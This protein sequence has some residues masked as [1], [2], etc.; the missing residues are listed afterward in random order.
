[1]KARL[2]AF[3]VHLSA[4]VI[5]ALFTVA[6][7]FFLWYPAPLQKAIGVTHI[8]LLILAID[9]ILGPLMTLVIYKTDKRKMAFDLTVIILLQLGAYFYG[10]HTV[11]AGRPAWLVFEVDRFTVVRPVDVQTIPRDTPERYRAF[12]LTGPEWVAGRVPTDPQ[13]RADL[14]FSAL[15]DGIDLAQRPDLYVP[16]VEENENLRANAQPLE[17]LAEFNPQEKVAAVLQ[18][19]PQAHAWFPLKTNRASMVVLMEKDGTLPLAIV[20]LHP[21][22]EIEWD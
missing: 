15:K 13:A 22:E 17:E 10:I 4:S 2:R 14:L 8:F 9:V 12:P 6:L 16:L 20:D 19:W 11:A 1:M 5:V 18:R 7:V 21:W 3:A